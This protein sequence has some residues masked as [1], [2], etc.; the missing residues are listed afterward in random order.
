MTAEGLMMI[1]I[2]RSRVWFVHPAK[3]DR[4]G[5]EVREEKEVRSV[6]WDQ[7]VLPA[8]GALR[9]RKAPSVKRVPQ[10]P[11]VLQAQ[12]ALPVHAVP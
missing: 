7:E 4:W 12:Q 1:K 10:G 3:E 9:V 11:K 8:K 2:K 5:R 6:P